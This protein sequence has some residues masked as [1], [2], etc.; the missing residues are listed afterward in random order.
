MIPVLLFISL[1]LPTGFEASSANLLVIQEPDSIQGNFI[2]RVDDIFRQ[3]E[4]DISSTDRMSLRLNSRYFGFYGPQ[5]QLY[6]D[7]IP[8]DSEFLGLIYSQHFPVSNSQIESISTASGP[9]LTN[10]QP[11]QTGR[12]NIQSSKTPEGLSLFYSG[13]IGHSGGEPGPWVYDPERVSPNIERFGPWLDGG[14][15]YGTDQ[16]Y[17]KGLVKYHNYLHVDP[18]VQNRIRSMRA[19]EDSSGLLEADANTLLGLIEVGFNRNR[20][21]IRARINQSRSDE[22]LFFQP[23]GREIPSAF[24]LAQ[25]SLD[26]NYDIIEGRT[27]KALYQYT[28]KEVGYRRNR[29]EHDLDWNQQTQSALF[30]FSGISGYE[31]GTHLKQ[32]VTKTGNSHNSKNVYTTVFLKNNYAINE[33]LTVDT[34]VSALLNY[35]ETAMSISTDLSY[36]AHDSYCVSLSW[37]YSQLPPQMSNPIDFQVMKGWTIYDQLQINS[38]LPDIIN[39]TELTGISLNQRVMISG[40]SVIGLNIVYT[41]H[42]S[43][44]IPNQQV[45]FDPDFNTMPGLYTLQNGEPGKRFGFNFN[46]LNR[47]NRNVTHSLRINHNRTISGTDAYRNYWASVSKTLIHYSLTLN[48]FQDLK[49]EPAIQYRSSSS[50]PEFEQIDGEQTRS[51]HTQYPASFYTLKNTLPSHFGF[52][53]HAAKW[54]WEQRLRTSI[55]LKNILNKEFQTHPLGVREGFGFMARLEVRI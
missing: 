41:N 1:F 34:F 50:W 55:Q 5:P 35:G 19:T 17:A 30:S 6:L 46:L 3:T 48:P 33:E 28:D 18:F 22:F 20:F 11:Y 45:Q 53:L 27:F 23:L 4:F 8:F 24:S 26:F 49:I 13:Q 37:F 40:R 12:V 36:S 15:S 21:D 32:V 38:D 52:D 10:G 7:G 9:G 43:I 25:Y 2:M 54:F 51:F 14:I 44:N 16:W 31:F 42:I 29:F 47:S 39:R